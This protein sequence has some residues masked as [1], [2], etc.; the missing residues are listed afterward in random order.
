MFKHMDKETRKEKL[1]NLIKEIK[2][3]SPESIEAFEILK[4]EAD[5]AREKYPH[6]LESMKSLAGQ[7]PS[8]QWIEAIETFKNGL[9][10]LEDEPIKSEM[11]EDPKASKLKLRNIKGTELVRLTIMILREHQNNEIADLSEFSRRIMNAVELK[12]KFESESFRRVYLQIIADM[13]QGLIDL[14]DNKFVKLD[15]ILYSKLGEEFEKIVM[16]LTK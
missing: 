13:E 14:E 12:N 8:P 6:L 2:P 5:A 1:M 11:P 10:K 7:K 4:R 9:K 3:L 15:R 16:N